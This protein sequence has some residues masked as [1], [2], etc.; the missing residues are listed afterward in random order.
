LQIGA[1]G[2]A[3]GALAIAADGVIFEPN[4][5]HLIAVEVVLNRLTEPW[6]GFRIVQLSDFHYDDH[7]SVIPLR[8]AVDISNGLQ[9]DLVV[10]TGDFVTGPLRG[11][12]SQIGK[13]LKEAASAIEPCAQWLSQLR[14]KNGIL[15][16]L[17]NH[18]LSTDAPHVTAVLEAHG[19]PVLINRS[20]A[21]ERQGKRL[22][23]SGVDDV[24]EGKPSLHQALSGIPV[25]EPVV[26]LVHEP[27]WADHVAMYPV[28]LQLS[29]HSHGG[30]I[31]LPLIGAP[32][33]PALGKKYPW[34][35]RHIGALT[36][37]TNVGVGTVR[38]PVR[39]GCPPEI[40]LC[41]LRAGEGT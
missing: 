21:L 39:L 8:K 24:L 5:P 14:A 10:L 4:R 15:A 33:L 34:G 23:L 35:L 28:D 26:L 25:D 19:I 40:T 37:Y 36:L 9:P 11:A 22:W 20:V 12:R 6:D 7:F 32:Y 16:V 38:I 29:G 41:T 1:A 18:D 17:G 27:D 30:Q 31:R 2:A 13:Q 3:L